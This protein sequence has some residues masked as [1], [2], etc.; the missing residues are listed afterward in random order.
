MSTL[1]TIFL[2]IM[3]V[4]LFGL[5]VPIFPGVVVIWL[6]ALTFG[7]IDGFGTLG[8][9]L[10]VFITLLLLVGVAVD[11]VLMAASARKSGAAWSSALLGVFAG[12]VGTIVFPPFGG[13]IA[14]PV[15]LLLLEYRRWGDWE[16]SWLA[17]KGL[18]IGWGLSFLAR[19]G[20]GLGMITMWLIWAWKG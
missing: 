1:E 6:A 10:F 13:L 7:L 8:V 19:F 4:G 3:L 20:I 18:L 17:V 15:V 12:L 11:N 2:I 5:V 9:I 16:R 14:A